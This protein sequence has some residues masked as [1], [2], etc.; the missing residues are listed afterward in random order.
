MKMK[1]YIGVLLSVLLILSFSGCAAET[2]N[3]QDT[4]ADIYK[5]KAT[6][7]VESGDIEAAIAVLEE[8]VSKTND[9]SLKQFL[10][11]LKRKNDSSTTS[12]ENVTTTSNENTT[13]LPSDNSID[14]EVEYDFDIS[15]YIGEWATS[16][17][18]WESGGFYLSISLNESKIDIAC[19]NVF[20]GRL[21]ETTIFANT[22]MII[23]GELKTGF[24]DS[25][26]NY[27]IM[28]LKFDSEQI[29][30]T[31]SDMEHSTEGIGYS[32]NEGKY[33]LHSYTK[34]TQPIETNTVGDYDSI[35]GSYVDAYG[36]GKYYLHIGYQ[37]NTKQK[38]VMMVD[39]YD[40][41]YEL[42]IE[43]S[44]DAE[45]TGLYMGGGSEPVCAVNM[46]IV[47]AGWIDA[48][49]YIGE[50][51]ELQEIMFMPINSNEAESK[52]PFYVD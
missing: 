28:S 43:G 33:T 35:V 18:S 36:P 52:N 10:D 5:N 51:G 17:F 27:G 42:P 25:W 9:D 6:E 38:A 12:T 11:E 47:E 48:E 30:C 40:K 22:S 24:E 14:S 4:F 23:N 29:V 32:L 16:G 13:T 34:P 39:L 31:I 26:G 20:S 7:Y 8:G 2:S 37:D 50:T 1:K 21:A 19:T 45:M 46:S 15:K 49:I 44:V 41:S 3:T